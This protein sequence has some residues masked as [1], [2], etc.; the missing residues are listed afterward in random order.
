VGC[1]RFL[2]AGNISYISVGI[3]CL[4]RFLAIHGND[5]DS[6][7]SERLLIFELEVDVLD[8]KG[9]DVVTEA[10]SRET[11]LYTVR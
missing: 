9:P 2:P 4:T 11:A 6:L 5:F 7:S 8:N 10:V 3:L 1:G